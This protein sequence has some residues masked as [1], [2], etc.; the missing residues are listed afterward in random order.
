MKYDSNTPLARSHSIGRRTYDACQLVQMHE[1]RPYV[2]SETA[3]G[4]ARASAYACA[5]KLADDLLHSQRG[6][7]DTGMSYR[8]RANSVE[9][10]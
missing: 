7:E 2:A 9:I 8:L 1:H 10:W 4:V 6:A 5:E 3:S